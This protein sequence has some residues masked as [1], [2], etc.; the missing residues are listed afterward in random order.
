V[1]VVPCVLALTA[2]NF[3]LVGC[4]STNK[5]TAN[6][7]RAPFPSGAGE[8]KKS[9]EITDPLAGPLSNSADTDALVAG[10]VI[11]GHSGR[12]TAAYVRW[13]C[14]DEA[15]EDAAPIDVTVGA[16]GYFTI[17]G[18]K[19]GK[20]YKLSARTKQ[21][22]RSL[23]GVQ[24]TM[25]PNIRV[26]IPMK[27]DLAPAAPKTPSTPGT[28]NAEPPENKTS[29]QPMDHPAWPQNP[30]GSKSGPVI[31]INQPIPV[32]A[33]E[34]SLPG[35]S[36]WQ[37]TPQ[38]S[39]P[40]P[41]T[42]PDRTKI[43]TGT[44][45]VKAP[46]LNIPSSTP[47]PSCLLVGPQL[48]NFALRDLNGE[49]WEYRRQ[50]RGKLMLLD[51]WSTTCPPCLESIP[52][53]RSLHDRYAGSGLQIVAIAYENS[54]S[55]QEQARRVSASAQQLKMNYQ[56]L[57]GAG[58]QCPVVSQFAVQYLPT[59]VL[60]GENGWIHWRHEGRLD[61]SQRED[62]ELRIQRWLGTR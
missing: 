58:K 43:A 55:A 47:V 20:H 38:I 39:Y 6:N 13:V 46:L 26:L 36:K 54:G 5:K 42:P 45:H 30:G 3:L 24:Y 57:L 17:Q 37:R 51:F 50:R 21:A 27:E 61:A 53:L 2:L 16:D 22:E 35:D 8:A 23:A 9:P 62:L 29:A 10:Q 7:E 19:R 31:R 15:K 34:S 59:I 4:A 12:P 52:H 41:T 28:K 14:L 33:T 49:T 44:G 48:H 18:L 60:I 56:V 40:Q 25:A 1:R 11:D 32:G